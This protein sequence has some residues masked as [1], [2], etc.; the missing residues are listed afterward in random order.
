[1][2][3]KYTTPRGVHIEQP[4]NDPSKAAVLSKYLL[5]GE[6]TWKDVCKRVA[7]FVCQAEKT[8]ELKSYWYQQYLEILLPMYFVPG[9]SILANS[10]HGTNGLNNCFVLETDDT[11]QG[12]VDLVSDS[13]MT[14]KFRGGV[15]IN[16]GSKG[17]PG[18]VREKGAP[19]KDGTALGPIAVLDMVSE[20]AKY[21]TTGNRHRRGAFLFSMHWKH[22]D[23]FDFIASKTKSKVDGEWARQMFE[24]ALSAKNEEEQK[25]LLAAFAA[26]WKETHLDA[27]GRRD[28]KWHNANISVQLDD[29]F[30]DLLDAGQERATVLWNRIA[31]LAHDTAD[32]G[33][34]LFDN[35]RKASPIGEF[36][37]TTNPCGELFLPANSSCNLGSLRLTA[38]AGKSGGGH[39]DINWQRLD[40]T[41]EIAVRFLDSVLS[42]SSYAT[43]AQ[44]ENIQN[45]YRQIGLGVMGWADYLKMVE[46]PYDSQQHLYQIESWGK[47]IAKTAYRASEALAE[48]L[49][50]CGIWDQIKD[51]RTG[52][53]FEAWV[54][55]A[56]NTWDGEEATGLAENMRLNQVPRRNSTVLSI[57]P[58]GSIAQ[59]SGSSWA[60]EPDFALVIWKQVFVDAGASKQQWLPIISPYLDDLNLSDEDKAKVEETGSLEGT[61]FAKDNPELAEVYKT[62][63]E[64]DPT[65]HIHVQGKWQQYVDSSISKT[66]NMAR[67]A[68]V[69]Q[70]QEVYRLAKAEGLKGIT[71]Y[72]NGT[73][74]SEPIKIGSKE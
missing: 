35:A 66:I 21:L 10:D 6:K 4:E 56:G 64:L 65:C 69:E 7:K 36:I 43:E 2:T 15:G 22:P 48:E 27:N 51:K 20:T 23:I 49:G 58:T 16:I 52:N 17:M 42:V 60:F 13:L 40:R 53:C 5:P 61:Q 67:E 57:A 1:M 54:D 55:K 45:V 14:T 34:L 46:V 28:R 47:R 63:G 62:A 19:Y 3:V 41:I 32:P 39:V 24:L 18:Y 38:F 30:F 68:T 73:L 26:G 12:I 70:I 29:E 33:L 44:K 72:R 37:R 25:G 11:M 71:V 9:G 8:D 50:P 74:E 59:L 31:Q